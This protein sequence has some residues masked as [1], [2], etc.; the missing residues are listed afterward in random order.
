MYVEQG[1]LSRHKERDGVLCKYLDVF[2]SEQLLHS[3]VVHGRLD[4]SSSEAVRKLLEL[5]DLG[6]FMS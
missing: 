3:L 6:L 2:L 1:Q 5:L 4:Q